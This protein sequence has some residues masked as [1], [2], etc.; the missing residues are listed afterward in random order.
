MT[1][2]LDELTE[3]L[4]ALEIERA[5]LLAARTACLQK[6]RNEGKSLRAIG[7]LSG[8]SFARVK[9]ILDAAR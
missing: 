1:N 3:R 4:A 7:E 2:N 6:W 9:Q 5:A 8:L